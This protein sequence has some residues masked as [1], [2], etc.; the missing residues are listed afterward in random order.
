MK[1][2]AFISYKHGVSTEFCLRLEQA[3]KGYA[4]PLLRPPIKI[5]RDEKHLVPATNL[6]ELIRNALVNSD[7]LFLIASD[8]SA[9]SPWVIDELKYWCDTL[10]RVD[11]LVVILTQGIIEVIEE[12]KRIDWTKTTALSQCLRDNLKHC[13]LYV[14]CTW[15]KSDSVLSLDNPQFKVVINQLS[16]RIHKKDPNEMLGEEVL[17]HRKNIR[18]RNLAVGFLT[19]LLLSTVI[20]LIFA[21]WQRQQA[22]ENLALAFLEKAENALEEKDPL[23]AEAFA[24][25]GLIYNDTFNL[26]KSLAR[27]RSYNLSVDWVSA[28]GN[29]IGRNSI[30]WSPN[31]KWIASDGPD[32]TIAIWDAIS[33]DQIAELHGHKD[34]SKL[35]WSPNEDY[36]AS[37]ST[38]GSVVVWDVKKRKTLKTLYGDREAVWG[39]AWSPDGKRLA[40]VGSSGDINIW[41]I[42]SAL[43]VASTNTGDIKNYGTIYDVSWSHNGN[44]IAICGTDNV[45]II[46]ET[47]SAKPISVKTTMSSAFACSWSPEGKFLAVGGAYRNDANNTIAGRIELWEVGRLKKPIIFNSHKHTVFGL[48]WSPSSQQFISTSGDG[49]ALV[50]SVKKGQPAAILKGFQGKPIKAFDEVEWSPDGSL[51]ATTSTKGLMIWDAKKGELRYSTAGHLSRISAVAWSSDGSKLVSA[52]W[53]GKVIVWDPVKGSE[54]IYLEAPDLV[55]DLAWHPKKELIAVTGRAWSNEKPRRNIGQIFVWDLTSGDIENSENTQSEARAVAWSVGGEQLVALS[56]DGTLNKLMVDSQIWEKIPRETEPPTTTTRGFLTQTHSAEGLSLE[57]D[58]ERIAY[59]WGDDVYIWNQRT[60]KLLTVLE[61]HSADVRTVAWS[62]DGRIIATGSLDTTIRLWDA[63]SYKLLRVFRGHQRGINDLRWSSFGRLLASASSDKTVRVWDP[64]IGIVW[65]AKGATSSVERISWSPNGLNLAGGTETGNLFVW[66]VDSGTLVGH[67]QPIEQVAWSPNGRQIASSSWDSE[68]I[69]WQIPEYKPIR[70]LGSNSSKK[71]SLLSWDPA[72]KRIA[73]ADR[74]GV[75]RL[76]GNDSS[77]SKVSLLSNTGYVR[78]LSWS[79]D[80][81]FLASLSWKGVLSEIDVTKSEEVHA[82]KVRTNDILFHGFNDRFNVSLSRQ[83]QQWLLA[84]AWIG[85]EGGVAVWNFKQEKPIWE[86]TFDQ[87]VNAVAWSPDGRFIAIRSKL[88]PIEILDSKTGVTLK[89]FE[90]SG[91]D[92]ISQLVWDTGGDFLACVGSA[93]I[94]I[95]DVKTGRKVQEISKKNYGVFMSATWSPRS[96]MIAV[97]SGDALIHIFHTNL[98]VYR[99]TPK[100]LLS[101]AHLNTRLHVQNFSEE[102]IPQNKLKPPTQKR[103]VAIWDSLLA[104][105]QLKRD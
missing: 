54:E 14:D 77:Q 38:D 18:L 35:K 70:S 51:I 40:S 69:M 8:E 95:F 1:F 31:G 63:K 26:R 82:F 59:T 28:H 78:A 17:Q 105:D 86:V 66:K 23:S 47:L 103:R 24:A 27:A 22:L 64:S 37:A 65:L 15:V 80:S 68:T 87:G 100:E 41:S 53:R 3:L 55:S 67:K 57:P 85:V 60:G 19:I 36:L 98:E 5:F 42:E 30:S 102:L 13:P 32:N 33:G 56:N 50:W 89:R 29:H 73:L 20:A 2:E 75:L 96:D 39:L 16:A 97:G 84:A 43:S 9:A 6:P 72:S 46:D 44:G 104:E 90:Q 4:K 91:L 52:D 49:S 62:P 12:T 88:Y 45:L 61:G 48:S 92:S 11:N 21:N 101:D 93:A 94:V 34:I 79:D 81:N 10:G 74:D 58:G 76:H 25:E 71:S 99:K 7:Y 83:G